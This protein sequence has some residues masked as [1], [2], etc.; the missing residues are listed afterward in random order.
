ML[1]SHTSN[2]L[3]TFHNE[4]HGNI[5]LGIVRTLEFDQ[6]S[7]FLLTLHKTGY[8]GTVGFFCDDISQD[9][10]H[11]FSAMGIYKENFKGKINTNLKTILF[12]KTNWAQARFG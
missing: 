4:V 1:D 5:I 11:K 10:L 6:V 2:A 12:N 9:S 8:T 7:N 3:P